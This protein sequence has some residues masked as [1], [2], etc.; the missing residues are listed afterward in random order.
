MVYVCE[1]AT[2]AV[3][4]YHRRF[5]NGRIPDTKELSNIFITLFQRGTQS[6]FSAT[7]SFRLHGRIYEAFQHFHHIA[8]AWYTIYV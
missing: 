3:R 5:P 4:E 8:S 1:K 7:I 6:M 2:A